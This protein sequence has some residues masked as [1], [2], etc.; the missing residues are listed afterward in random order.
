MLRFR[1]RDLIGR[2]HAISLSA[3]NCVKERVV[4]HCSDRFRQGQEE[5]SGGTGSKRTCVID[6][7]N[8]ECKPWQS[9]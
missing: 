6:S 4:P 2:H 9:L 8:E 1:R 7:L 3:R 5:I